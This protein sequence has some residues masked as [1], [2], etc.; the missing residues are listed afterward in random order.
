MSINGPLDFADLGIF[1][2]FFSLTDRHSFDLLSAVKGEQCLRPVLN[3]KEIDWSEFIYRAELVVFKR[4]LKSAHT[5]CLA[6]L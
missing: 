6:L 3:H 2:L 5:M 1:F 4:P